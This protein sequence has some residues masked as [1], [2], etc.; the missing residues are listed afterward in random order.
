MWAI[1]ASS[2]WLRHSASLLQHWLLGG[3][4][5]LV[6]LSSAAA[7]W[8]HRGFVQA[9]FAQCQWNVA[10][11][12][13]QNVKIKMLSVVQVGLGA[14]TALPALRAAGRHSVCTYSHV[15]PAAP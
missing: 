13:I 12:V 7:C 4:T 1:P 2:A 6:C 14:S 3:V 9:H 15:L 11:L 5:L 10:C 8:A